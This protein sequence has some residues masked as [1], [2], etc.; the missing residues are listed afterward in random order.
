MSSKN[1]NLVNCFIELLDATSFKKA[2]DTDCILAGVLVDSD[3]AASAL[4]TSSDVSKLS[5][6][7]D[8]L[9]K[10]IPPEYHDFI[11]VF[12][13][14]EADALPPH[15]SY[16]HS[17]ELEPGTTPPHG[18]IYRLS[19]LE[20]E[21][22]RAY[23]DE[24]LDKGFIRSSNSPAGAPILFVRKKD[25]SLRLCV[26]YRGLNCITKKNRYPL[27]LI[28]TLLDRLRS[29]RLFTK[30]DL[31]G[32]YN[33]IRIAAGDEW[34]TAFRTRFGSFEYLVIPFGMCNAPATFQ[35]FINDIF[36]DLLDRYVSPYLDDILIF[37][38]GDV[39]LHIQH[40]RET[41]RRLRENN[42]YCKIEKCSFH[43]TSMEFL[44]YFVSLKG[45]SM[46]SSK[47]DVISKWPMPW[48]IQEIQSF[49]GFAN[50]LPSFHF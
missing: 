3:L 5:S 46:D 1:N 23:L 44:G 2:F 34:K 36:H 12:S 4:S 18:P 50:F 16:D 22:L 15:R 25:G 45:I 41:L 28:D 17:I 38:S 13:K 37:T 6:E 40:V 39:P 11:N 7:Q 48:N 19:E 10:L 33:L 49:L 47:M 8:E 14:T 32:A 31:R 27:P 30:L 20:L 43:V 29:S 35:H 9:Q 26:D 42:L 24:H 21:T